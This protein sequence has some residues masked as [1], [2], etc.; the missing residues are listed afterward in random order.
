MFR[1]FL[2]LSIIFV[3]ISGCGKLGG[4]KWLHYDE[5]FCADKWEK[6]VNNEKLKNNITEYLDKKG[7]KVFEIEIFS[8]ITPD[9]CTECACKTGRRIKCKV[10]SGDV[11]E[12]KNEKFY[13]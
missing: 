6:N 10:S 13:E 3:L 7:I 2:V 9:S 4:V 1:T 11:S 12:L 8:D 5:T